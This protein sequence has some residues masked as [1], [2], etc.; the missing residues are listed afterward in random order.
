[1]WLPGE[2]FIN[3]EMFINGTLQWVNKPNKVITERT[4]INIRCDNEP[5]DAKNWLN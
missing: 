3:P 2:G 4:V 1:V 5:Q